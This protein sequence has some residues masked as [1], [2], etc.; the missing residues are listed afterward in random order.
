LESWMCEIQLADLFN[1][2]AGRI[3]Y[4]GAAVVSFYFHE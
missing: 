2:G 4:A 3:M 1:T